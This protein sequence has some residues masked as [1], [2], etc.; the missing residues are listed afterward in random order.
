MRGLVQ[1]KVLKIL[2]ANCCRLVKVFGRR[3]ITHVRLLSESNRKLVLGIETSCDDTG[4]A[5]VD[6]HGNIVGDALN[7]QTRFHVQ[8]GGI[9]PPFARDLH[10]ENIENVVEKSLTNAHVKLEDMTAIA[11]TVKPGLPLSLL[12]GLT[13]AKQL[14]L[15]SSKPLIPIHHMEAHALTARMTHGV[16]FPFLVLL[17]SGGHCLLAVAQDVDDFLLLGRGIDDSPGDAFDKTARRLKL[18]NI[19]QFAS[20]SGGEAVE[21]TAQGG[22]PRAFEFPAAVMSHHRHCDFS[23][24]GLKYHAHKLI[25]K[26][27]AKYDT[28]PDHIIP[29]APDVCA[30][31]QFSV[32][33]HLAQRLQRGFLFCDLKGLLDSPRTLVVSGGVASNQFIRSGL[34]KVCAAHDCSLVCPPAHLCTDNGVMIAW[35]G[36]EKLQRGIDLRH[37]VDSL[38]IQ[39][40]CPL[41]VD[42]REEVHKATIKLRRIKLL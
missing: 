1:Q 41:G 20:M 7:S 6:D 24:A 4:A 31:F 10:Q 42:L 21:R 26:E 11:V 34:E 19:A 39:A 35:N 5:V 14:A 16:R 23:F 13:Y 40:K 33:R 36:M 25:E 22:D 9:I 3:E 29:S 27:E 32:L 38:D 18:K 2:C 8:L 15:R 12:V 17:L 37:D 30:S 28:A